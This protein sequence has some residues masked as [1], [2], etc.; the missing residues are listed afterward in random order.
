MKFDFFLHSIIS[1]IMAFKV[2][3]ATIGARDSN[4]TSGI[5]P[6][7]FVGAILVA[8]IVYCIGWTKWKSW[9]QYL[10]FILV[11]LMW[12]TYCV[13]IAAILSR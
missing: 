11:N 5:L 2:M 12:W 8:F 1:L 13:T 6:G 4:L 3:S 9:K 10:V 7:S